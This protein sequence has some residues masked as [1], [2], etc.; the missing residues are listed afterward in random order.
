MDEQ[1]VQPKQVLPRKFLTIAA[2]PNADSNITLSASSMTPVAA[3]SHAT[4]NKRNRIAPSATQNAQETI[5]LNR[6]ERAT[7]SNSQETVFFNSEEGALINVSGG[8]SPI[9]ESSLE[10]FKQAIQPYLIYKNIPIEAIIRDANGDFLKYILNTEARCGNYAEV[11]QDE[12]T[13]HI[14]SLPED[15]CIQ[16]SKIPLRLGP[17]V[18]E[19]LQMDLTKRIMAQ[20]PMIPAADIAIMIHD[21][22]CQQYANPKIDPF[23]M[24]EEFAF[25][26]RKKDTIA[27]FTA[28]AKLIKARVEILDQAERELLEE[29]DDRRVE[30]GVCDPEETFYAVLLRRVAMPPR[31]PLAQS[32]FL[33]LFWKAK[34]S[35]SRSP[36]PH[37]PNCCNTLVEGP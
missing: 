23:A 5:T 4:P 8:D 35:R 14:M 20:Y 17:R 27:R 11:T 29:W 32:D 26:H 9:I 12:I 34:V 33:E 24:I 13:Q 31:N 28:S 37:A 21:L 22:I 10:P 19:I 1:T 2:A 30:N 25:G 16:I 3:P 36:Y 18:E 15:H 6:Q 7:T